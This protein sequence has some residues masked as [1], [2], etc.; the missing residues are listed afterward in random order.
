MIIKEARIKGIA[1]AGVRLA[2][3]VMEE[4]KRERELV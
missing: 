3:S 1:V 2:P 4:Y